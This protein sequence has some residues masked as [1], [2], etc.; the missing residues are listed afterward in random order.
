MMC[1]T[2]EKGMVLGDVFNTTEV[3]E[4][5]MSA[6]KTIQEKQYE[7]FQVSLTLKQTINTVNLEQVEAHAAKMF[8]SLQISIDNAFYERKEFLN[9]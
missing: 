3:T 6:S 8:D 2:D 1:K 5:E 9:Q 4:L 7:P